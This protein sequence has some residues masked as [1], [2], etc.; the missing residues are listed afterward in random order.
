MSICPPVFVSALFS[1]QGA[2]YMQ[3]EAGN[4]RQ[5]DD[6]VVTCCRVYNKTLPADRGRKSRERGLRDE[7]PRI[8]SGTLMHN[9][10]PVIVMFLNFKHQIACVTMKKLIN[11]KTPTEY[12]LF[13]KST[14]STSTK[15]PLHEEINIFLARTR[16]KIPLRMHKNTP[17]QVKNSIF[18]PGRA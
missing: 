17:F 8:W 14:S 4:W 6:N 9:V 1:V 13:P 16:T 10:P 18:F 11:P 15:S 7:S 12:S 2:G 5:I 3:E